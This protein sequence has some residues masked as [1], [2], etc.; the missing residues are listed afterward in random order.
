MPL[1]FAHVFYGFLENLDIRFEVGFI[2]GDM[3]GFSFMLQVL[4]DPF[5]QIDLAILLIRVHADFGGGQ[6]RKRDVG[7]FDVDAIAFGMVDY[8]W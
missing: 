8:F 6:G 7:L 4:F 2:L 1:H 3:V 5:Q